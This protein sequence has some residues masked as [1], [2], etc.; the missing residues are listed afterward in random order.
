[1]PKPLKNCCWL[2]LYL[3][4]LLAWWWSPFFVSFFIKWLQLHNPDCIFYLGFVFVIGLFSIASFF[5]IGVAISA[6]RLLAVQLHLR[7]QALGTHTR[8]AV[9]STLTLFLVPYAVLT[10][11]MSGI[12]TFCLLVTRAIYCKI[13]FI[14]RRHKR[15]I[16]QLRELEAQARQNSEMRNL[17]T[18][19]KTAVGVL[20][21]YFA[22]LVWYSP[23]FI[24]LDARI[25]IGPNIVRTSFSLYR[26]TLMF[27]NSTL[28]LVIYGWRMRQTRHVNNGHTTNSIHQ[29]WVVIQDRK[30]DIHTAIH[31]F[32]RAHSN[33]HMIGIF[34]HSV[35]HLMFVEIRF[36]IPLLEHFRCR[37][38][39]HLG[40]CPDGHS[41][42]F[43]FLCKVLIWPRHIFRLC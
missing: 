3:M 21:V 43:N 8:V 9:F 30:S 33:F 34:W 29:S 24:L 41:I 2:L 1:M 26:H 19:M 27:F 22:F 38:P 35:F 14:T 36:L 18:I 16:Q 23:R 20:Y 17:A 6:D 12:G 42:Q 10:A 15:Q 40:P 32:F 13:C 4:L 11:I 37:A 31:R 28:N 7:Y 5:N 39:F 25:I